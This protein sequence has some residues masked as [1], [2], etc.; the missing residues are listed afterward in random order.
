MPLHENCLGREHESGIPRP[1]RPGLDDPAPD[2]ALP[3]LSATVTA[4]AT[5]TPLGGGR[6]QTTRLN[7]R[8]GNDAPR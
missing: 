6:E 1:S 7:W 2:P 3:S 8:G 4:I 5:K